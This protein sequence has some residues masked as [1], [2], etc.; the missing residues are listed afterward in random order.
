MKGQTVPQPHT[1]I[2][3]IAQI[4]SRRLVITHNIDSVV[5]WEVCNCHAMLY[6][7]EHSQYATLWHRTLPLTTRKF[8]PVAFDS[9]KYVHQEFVPWHLAN[10]LWPRQIK[11]W[12]AMTVWHMAPKTIVLVAFQ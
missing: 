2:P 12:V 8:F 10:I 1:N 7:S 11:V 6:S 3:Q 4:L 9:A 5:C